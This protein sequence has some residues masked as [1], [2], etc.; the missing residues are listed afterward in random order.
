M[1]VSLPTRPQTHPAQDYLGRTAA[2]ST[3]R[4]TTWPSRPA[5][6]RG[7]ARSFRVEFLLGGANLLVERTTVNRVAVAGRR[8]CPRGQRLVVLLE[9]EENVAVMILNDGVRSELI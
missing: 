2:S 5:P 4:R 7:R 6:P 8:E 9:L 1:R 3:S